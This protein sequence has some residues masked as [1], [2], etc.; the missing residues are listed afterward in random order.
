M[1][2]NKI[3]VAF[4]ALLIFSGCSDELILLN[5]QSKLIQFGTTMRMDLQTKTY[6][7]DDQDG[8]TICWQEN[9]DHI[10]IYAID[11]NGNFV[12]P[13]V[14]TVIPN[15]YS[16]THGSLS[17]GNLSWRPGD[18]F[19]F[20]GLY[21]ET[22]T[23]NNNELSLT[24]S[25]EQANSVDMKQVYM[26]ARTDQGYGENPVSLD[27][28]P[29]VTTITLI[30]ENDRENAIT[31]ISDIN[32][33]SAVL[34][35]AGTYTVNVG[36]G[37]GPKLIR[38][39]IDW[40]A[41]ITSEDK[42]ISIEDIEDITIDE[43]S[44]HAFNILLIPQ[45]YEGSD[46]ELSFNVND[47]VNEK[48]YRESLEDVGTIE[49]G[50]RYFIW[51]AIKENGEITPPKR[52]SPGGAQMILSILKNKGDKKL[53]SDMM[54]FLAEYLGY[55]LPE[56][57]EWDY[58][59][60]QQDNSPEAAIITSI[61]D[62]ISN[63]FGKDWDNADER[64]NPESNVFPN[65]SDHFTE[66]ELE[67]LKAFLATVKDSGTV[68]PDGNSYISSDVE[69]SDFDWLPNLERM[70][71]FQANQNK[72]P[73]PE[74]EIEGLESLTDISMNWVG[75]VS[76]SNCGGEDGITIHGLDNING[77]EGT[78]SLK[79][80][81]LNNNPLDVSNQSS[82][83]GEYIFERVTNV[84]EIKLGSAGK[85]SIIDCDDLSK[86]SISTG[87]NLTELIIEDCDSLVSISLQNVNPPIKI[88]LKNC[89]NLKTITHINGWEIEISD[90]PALEN[91]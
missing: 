23:L 75:G 60:I 90:C 76:I 70:D 4:F 30:V 45:E 10:M 16:P 68:G 91:Y 39:D 7:D 55:N 17:G 6:Y 52:L 31:T 84:E 28:Y 63:F 25:A 83:N 35:L 66:K 53:H 3:L 44:Y 59:K 19:R 65:D 71:N 26:V 57:G 80:L 72:N 41:N 88:I 1:S 48:S 38:D 22:L 58:W 74:I 5:R 67:I 33:T 18:T 85:V 9:N 62:K 56:G 32:L 37:Q 20:Y 46:I 2:R 50:H 49:P 47:S 42:T 79:D 11:D 77:S 12:D 40:P 87:N 78:V 24:V 81:K 13:S 27:F 15:P 29:L 86:L 82:F 61:I 51:V 36:K 34:S 54:Y 73:R 14:Y 89:K 43:K 21:P 69:A 64:F 8:G